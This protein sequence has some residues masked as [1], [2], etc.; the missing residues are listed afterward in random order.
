M[1]EKKKVYGFAAQLQAMSPEEKKTWFK[2]R[3]QRALARV[4]ARE[5]ELFAWKNESLT[6][7]CEHVKRLQ[8]NFDDNTVP[9]ITDLIDA[10]H[11]LITKGILPMEIKV[12]FL[13]ERVCS[14]DGWERIKDTLVEKRLT[15]IKDMIVESF[16]SQNS[17]REIISRQI[18]QL[19]RMKK[20]KPD[21]PII[22][23]M[24]VDFTEKLFRIEASLMN[25]LGTL[26]IVGEKNKKSGSIIHLHTMIPRPDSGVPAIAAEFKKG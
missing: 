26:G 11:T 4:A 1:A 23:K 10:I 12:K 21:D 9:V 5:E 16:V 7:L 25:D 19:E 20:R 17:A 22:H 8:I 13:Q 24:I 3:S 14:E 2:E 6:R 15:N 18:G